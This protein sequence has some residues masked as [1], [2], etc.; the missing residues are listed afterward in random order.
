[1]KNFKEIAIR[2]FQQGKIVEKNKGIMVANALT[3]MKVKQLKK[4]CYDYYEILY[5]SSLDPLYV[6]RGEEDAAYEM[7]KR[8]SR[9]VAMLIAERVLLEILFFLFAFFIYYK[10]I[11]PSQEYSDPQ[12]IDAKCLGSTDNVGDGDDFELERVQQNS[13]WAYR[14]EALP[15]V[16]RETFVPH[17]GTSVRARR[18]MG[19]VGNDVS[20]STGNWYLT[21]RISYTNEEDG[22]K[23]K[24]LH[25]SPAFMPPSWMEV[26]CTIPKD[27]GTLASFVG[28][29]VQH[30]NATGPMKG[31]IRYRSETAFLSTLVGVDVAEV[32]A[33]A[34][35][36]A[37]SAL[38]DIK[39]EES[40]K[41]SSG[42]S[43]QQE[44]SKETPPIPPDAV[45]ITGAGE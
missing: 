42:A 15:S 12:L 41:I 11:C 37:F 14:M 27:D 26:E 44:E 21:D 22:G 28:F 32:A 5:F 10:K 16:L 38:E 30:N 23:E 45:S 36:A 43:K 25:P 17:R 1:M 34:A 20:L 2:F 9:C 4:L 6:K 7:R 31:G 35:L 19:S 3:L 33:C 8:K 13:K 40:L 29:R 24:C 18:Y 39:L